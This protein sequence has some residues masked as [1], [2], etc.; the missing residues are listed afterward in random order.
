LESALLFIKGVPYSTP[1]S[2]FFLLLL[3][4]FAV[5]PSRQLQQDKDVALPVS[6]PL[7]S[8]DQLKKWDANQVVD[9]ANVASVKLHARPETRGAQGPRLLLC[10]DMA[11]KFKDSLMAI[12]LTLSS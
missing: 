11:G 5:M 3:F 7:T 12:V 6:N 1:S 10:H 4:C 9:V 2:L 8:M